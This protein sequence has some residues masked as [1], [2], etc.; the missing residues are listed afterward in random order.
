[1]PST[2]SRG[3]PILPFD[4]ELNRTLHKMNNPQNTATHCD[5]IN[6]KLPPPVEAHNQVIVE[7]TGDVVVRRQPPDPTLRSS[8]KEK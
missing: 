3:E 2:Q 6:H 1:M 7:N 5:W 4:Q 8:I